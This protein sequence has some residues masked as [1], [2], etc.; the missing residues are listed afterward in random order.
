MSASAF[1]IAGSRK[2]AL[3]HFGSRI[4]NQAVSVRHTDRSICSRCLTRIGVE[5]WAHNRENMSAIN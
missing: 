5:Q 2:S 4:A 3:G 1:P